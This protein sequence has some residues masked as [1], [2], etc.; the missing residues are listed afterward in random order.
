[1]YES[2]I[3]LKETIALGEEIME[4]ISGGKNTRA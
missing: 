2:D 4:D 1:M 3:F